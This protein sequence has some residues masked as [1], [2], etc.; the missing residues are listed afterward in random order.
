MT[1]RLPKSQRHTLLQSAP[2]EVSDVEDDR[3]SFSVAQKSSMRTKYR[4]LSIAYACIFSTLIVIPDRTLTKK[5]ASKLGGAGGFGVAA[6]V[7]W[8]LS[9]AND[10]ERL[11]SQ[12]SRRLNV[13]LL[14]FSSLGLL[15]V[16]G[17]AAFTTTAGAA[18]VLAAAMNAA[19]ILGIIAA[20]TGWSM[21]VGPSSEQFAEERVRLLAPRKAA[22]E[23]WTGAKATIKSLKVTKESKKRSLTYRNCALLVTMSM[24]SCLME[25][26]FYMRVSLSHKQVFVW[27]LAVCLLQQNIEQ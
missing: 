5:L 11:H 3:P 10:N 2:M 13:G 25:G 24:I 23:L 6:G 20:Y 21:G 4:M 1:V 12:T 15:A 18:M 22:G 19:R 27:R 16:P 17:E 8:M 14:G 26:I 9:S 7:S